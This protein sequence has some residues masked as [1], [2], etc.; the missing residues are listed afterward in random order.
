MGRMAPILPDEA[1]SLLVRSDGGEEAASYLLLFYVAAFQGRP[2]P[3]A[4][5]L[6]LRLILSGVGA[7]GRPKS[8][9]TSVFPRVPGTVIHASA[10]RVAQAVPFPEER[11]GFYDPL[12]DHYELLGTPAL[13]P[14]PP[15]DHPLFLPRTKRG[16]RTK[17]KR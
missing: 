4:Y 13:S 16:A 9:L 14:T 5:G 7:V 10:L 15:P 6:R 8:D 11:R 3:A 12:L 17:S 1:K 2:V